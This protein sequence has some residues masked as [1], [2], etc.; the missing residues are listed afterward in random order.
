MTDLFLFGC[1]TVGIIAHLY[2][3]RGGCD[4][5]RAIGKATAALAFLSVALLQNALAT[6][7]GRLVFVGLLFGA[8]GDILMLDRANNK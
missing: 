1:A 2:Y 3:E 7:A 6:V 4:E 8:V 5:V